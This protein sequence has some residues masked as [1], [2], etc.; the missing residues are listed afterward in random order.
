MEME[1]GGAVDSDVVFV[2]PDGYAGRLRDAAPQ[3]LCGLGG[4]PG[5]R[6]RPGPAHGGIWGLWGHSAQGVCLPAKYGLLAQL[7]QPAER[8]VETSIEPGGP[9][10]PTRTSKR[11]G[12]GYLRLGAGGDAGLSGAGR[13]VASPPRAGWTGGLRGEKS[14]APETVGS[15]GFRPLRPCHEFPGAG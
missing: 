2:R 12:G 11:A 15:L 8:R 6:A 5:A 1:E 10:A 3:R 7:A 9:G 13:E 14:E 4:S